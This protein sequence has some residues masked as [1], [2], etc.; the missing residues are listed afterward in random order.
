MSANIA[1]FLDKLKLN[2]FTE[3]GFKDAVCKVIHEKTT[4]PIGKECVK[5]MRGLIVIKVDS[6]M[7]MEI[8]MKKMEILNTLRARYPKRMIKDII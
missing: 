8:S 4:F 5:E 1:Q 7:K 6:Y 3:D 2:L